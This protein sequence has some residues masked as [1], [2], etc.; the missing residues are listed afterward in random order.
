[1]AIDPD[2]TEAACQHAYTFLL[3]QGAPELAEAYA[4]R[5]RGHDG[6]RAA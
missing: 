3:R 5:Y 4:E 2:A 6:A 1:M